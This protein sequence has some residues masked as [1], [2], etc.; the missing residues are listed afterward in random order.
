[1]GAAGQYMLLVHELKLSSVC[2]V[3]AAHHRAHHLSPVVD[4]SVLLRLQC[5]CATCAC[6]FLFVSISIQIRSHMESLSPGAATMAS[7]GKQLRH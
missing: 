7:V 4:V 5:V 2:A 6:L 1:M 3:C